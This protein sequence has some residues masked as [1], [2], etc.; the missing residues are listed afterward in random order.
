[1]HSSNLE[2]AVDAR[3]LVPLAV[4]TLRG[5]AEI[6]F[7]LYLWPSKDSPPCLYREKCVPLDPADLQQLLDESVVTLYTPASQAQ[8]YCDLVRNHVLA[9]E[10]IPARERYRALKDAT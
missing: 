1:M 10:T 6:A 5:R 9:D 8:K 7:D 3:G 2:T 4:K